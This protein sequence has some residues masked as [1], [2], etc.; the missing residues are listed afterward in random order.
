MMKAETRFDIFNFTPGIYRIGGREEPFQRNHH[1]RHFTHCVGI[2]VDACT[3][4]HMYMLLLSCDNNKM[5]IMAMMM[6]KNL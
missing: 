1:S 3:H 4:E 6:M 5:M 2:I